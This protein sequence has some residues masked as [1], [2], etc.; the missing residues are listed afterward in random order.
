V[1]DSDGTKIKRMALPAL[2]AVENKEGEEVTITA[3]HWYDNQG[4]GTPKQPL[5]LC[6]AFTNGLLQLG[7]GE[8]DPS[9]VIIDAE[10][11]VTHCRWNADGSALAVTG[12]QTTARGDQNKTVNLIKFYDPQG[13][14]MRSIR[15]P[16][17][18]VAALSW[19]GSGLRLALAVDAFIF[20]AN[21]RPSYQWAYIE[22]TVVYSFY[23]VVFVI[24][25]RY[26]E[27]FNPCMH[28]WIFIQP[29]IVVHFHSQP[30]D[31]SALV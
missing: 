25:A 17:E 13:Q 16:G 19:E 11:R 22:N 18:E 31:L 3:M 10:M 14:Y 23:K 2:Q 5:P 29:L 30:S 28:I 12:I 4:L 9:P 6:V 20:F 15:I 8:D 24:A 21:I 26:Y 27:G 7:R 1:Y